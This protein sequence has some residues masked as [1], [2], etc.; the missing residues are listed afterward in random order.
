MGEAVASYLIPF[1][2]RCHRS[3]ASPSSSSIPFRR[4]RHHS[5]AVA[6]LPHPTSIEV[7]IISAIH[8]L[9]ILHVTE[10]MR[11]CGG[12][13]GVWCCL[14]RPQRKLLPPPN[15][16][17]RESFSGGAPPSSSPP[18]RLRSRTTRFCKPPIPSCWFRCKAQRDLLQ[19][20][21]L[22]KLQAD[23]RGILV[24]SNAVGTLL[25]VQAIS[26]MQLLVR[27]RHAQQSQGKIRQLRVE[28]AV[29]RCPVHHTTIGL[30]Q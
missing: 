8:S 2:R 4:R 7:T 12:D 15:K 28:H 10:K 1:R 27:A 3:K 13:H 30:L 5:K 26:K 24:H 9:S 22:V 25:C 17:S 6:V 16:G 20:K 29:K 14:H 23:V 19:L 11:R 21:N 18:P